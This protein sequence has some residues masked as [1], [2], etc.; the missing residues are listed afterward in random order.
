MTVTLELPTVP[1]VSNPE[2]WYS[3][4]PTAIAAAK[5]VCDTCP[6]KRECLTMAL[7]A[8]VGEPVSLRFGIFGGM[9]PAERAAL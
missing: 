6:E 2:G 1:C 8:E 5:A 7:R 4:H 3:G 9:T